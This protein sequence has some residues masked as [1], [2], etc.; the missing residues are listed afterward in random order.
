MELRPGPRG[1]RQHQRSGTASHGVQGVAI[2]TSV[3]LPGSPSLGSC[4]LCLALGP[5]H[6]ALGIALCSCWS[7]PGPRAPVPAC[8]GSTGS[9]GTY[10]QGPGWAGRATRLRCCPHTRP[11]SKLLSFWGL[12]WARHM[13]RCRG[14]RVTLNPCGFT[15]LRSRS[16]AASCDGLAGGS[17]GEERG[18]SVG[19]SDLSA[20]S[21]KATPVSSHQSR[22]P[23]PTRLASQVP[24][25]APW[26]SPLHPLPASQAL[27][28]QR[29]GW[30]QTG[31]APEPAWVP[32]GTSVRSRGA[33]QPWDEI[34]C[35]LS[36]GIERMHIGQMSRPG[37]GGGTPHCQYSCAQI[38]G[39]LSG[40]QK[41]GNRWWRGLRACR[42]SSP[43]V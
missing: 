42:S 6:S 5:Q 36:R 32:G 18:A 3:C 33:L 12:H 24:R 43:A 39:A 10:S 22:W 37:T 30:G 34:S 1:S 40:G 15:V 14:R 19:A 35:F 9:G 25:W 7:P 26:S 8:R 28:V 29:V 16:G 27:T 17:H 20:S 38:H 11:R 41:A 31:P 13:P 21:H 4:G 23:C 2:S